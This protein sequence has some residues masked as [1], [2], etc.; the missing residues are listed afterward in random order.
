MKVRF[1]GTGTSQGVPVIACSCPVCQ[2]TDSR[3]KRLR[4]SVLLE[5]DNGYN[6]TIDTGPDFRYQM[7]RERVDHLDAILMTHSHKDHIAG[8]DDVRAFNYHQQQSISIYADAATLE[9]L[10]REFYYAFSAVKYPGVP[11][12]DLE[13]I[14]AE[15]PFS[16]FDHEVIPFEVLH[17]KMPVMGY[18]I[19]AF[20]YITD[21]KTVS[22]ETRKLLEGLDVL[23]VN[24]LQEAPHISHFTLDEALSFI[25]DVKPQRAYLTHISH[26]F[27][28]HEYIESLLPEGVFVAYDQ[29]SVDVK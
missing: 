13:E 26:R 1:L 25:A 17:Y 20:A 6:V 22:K 12:L 27:G 5:M 10:Q 2:S 29:L 9:A 14:K 19:G 28:K 23:V 7:L 8:L 15:M 24:A 18:R 16:L 3:D 11:Q 4:T 21:A